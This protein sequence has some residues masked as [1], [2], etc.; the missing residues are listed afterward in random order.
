M[1]ALMN[2]SV[3]EES[4]TPQPRGCAMKSPLPP[5]SSEERERREQEMT[6]AIMETAARNLANGG[7]RY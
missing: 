5:L 2:S 4:A 6:A 3:P 1:T 7:S